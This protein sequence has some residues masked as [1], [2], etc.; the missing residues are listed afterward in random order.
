MIPLVDLHW[1]HRLLREELETTFH[2]VIEKGQ[3]IL[4]SQVRK[5]E[6]QFS[7]Y[8]NCQYAIGASSGTDALVLVLK[9]LDIQ[10]GDE[11]IVPAM[12][13][14]ATAE[15]V[16]IVGATPVIVDV[17]PEKL[18]LDSNLT[19]EAISEKTKAI[20][21]VHLHGWPVPLDP[22][23]AMAEKHNLAVI[24]DCAQAHGAR[25]NGYPVGSR[26]IAGCFSFF[27]GKNLGA[28]GD[29]GMVV[30]NHPEIA[31]KVK[32][33]ANHGRK[34]KY[35]HELVGYNARL[36]ELQAAF[37][38]VKFAYLEEWNEQRRN[39][40]KRYN[41]AFAKLPLQTPPE[42]TENLVP[43]YHLYV[44]HCES[45]KVRNQLMDFLKKHNVQSGIHYPVPLNMQPGLKDLG[46]EAGGFPI[47][48]KASERIISLPIYPGM[49]LEQQNQVI[50]TVLDFFA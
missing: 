50:E 25:E 17:E 28:L 4:G 2:N 16:C 42:T 32:L 33:L 44:L 18:G 39:L 24:E 48:E 19:S 7:E 11:V 10:P 15:A 31:Q 14:Y 29:A 37:I 9:A 46:Y 1:Q 35:L 3:F 38:N 45:S 5:L 23:L 30:T 6:E 26:S 20:L 22:F 41:Q 36:D 47:S 49:S 34:E 43:S 40:A 13:F 12:T 27:P 8:H 21:P